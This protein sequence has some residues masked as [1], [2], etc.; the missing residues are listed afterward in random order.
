MIRAMSALRSA[1]VVMNPARRE[2]A[3]NDDVS[4]PAAAAYCVRI[5][6]TD[7]VG[8]RAGLASRIVIR[9]RPDRDTGR[10]TGPDVM[11]PSFS[12]SRTKATGRTNRT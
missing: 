11:P 5:A 2:C 1:A 8:R 7:C 3:P 9:T 12:H 6:A 4:S 10:N